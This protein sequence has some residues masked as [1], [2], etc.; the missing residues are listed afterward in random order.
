M[1]YKNRAE[2]EQLLVSREINEKQRQ[3]ALSTIRP[4][5]S[6]FASY[7]VLEIADDEVDLTDGY[8]FG[9][10]LQWTLFDGGAAVA[11]ARQSETD[12]KIDETQFANQRNQIRL[13]VE[14]GYYN[15]TA[16]QENITTSAKAVELAEESL[17]LARLR[18]QAG[19][20][21]Q[22]DVIQAQSELTTAR[23][24][25][26]SAIIDYNQALNQLERS[27]TNL[28]EGKLFDLPSN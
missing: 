17:R 16:S 15:L 23:G 11:R 18:F 3:I 10:R 19:V 9:T 21:T 24:N 7:D 1:A 8:S 5:V 22:T 4:Q 2:L 28:P 13:Q 27:V 14:Q 20:G 26:F 6:L 25:F 12:I